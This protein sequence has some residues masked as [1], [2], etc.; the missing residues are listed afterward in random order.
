MI[1]GSKNQPLALD[2]FVDPPG[3][4]L[5]GKKS[6]IGG[7]WH[8]SPYMPPLN[9]RAA[10][11]PREFE[12][13]AGGKVAPVD[14]A[15]GDQPSSL[16]TQELGQDVHIS[17]GVNNTFWDTNISS[18]GLATRSKWHPE[19]I[20]VFGENRQQ[21]IAAYF[22]GS[23][24][25]LG[26]WTLEIYRLDLGNFQNGGGGTLATLNFGFGVVTPGGNHTLHLKDEGG[27]IS[28][29]I[30]DQPGS[31][32]THDIGELFREHTYGG[33]Y[34]SQHATFQAGQQQGCQFSNFLAVRS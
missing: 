26:G 14:P 21:A 3:T 12:V 4:L 31:V 29:W 13:I 11:S 32:L 27:L 30:E 28:T 7:V 17:C 9:G 18:I 33:L 5:D 20:D 23:D 1:G 34:I 24:N 6:P 2:N 8:Q 25:G 16:Y 19:F 10:I 15:T 22:F